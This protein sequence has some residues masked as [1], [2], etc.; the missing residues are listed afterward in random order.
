MEKTRV[1]TC[2]RKTSDE[3]R[4]GFRERDDLATVALGHKS[5]RWRQQRVRPKSAD[6]IGGIERQLRHI[7]LLHSQSLLV[8]RGN[9]E[10]LTRAAI[11]PPAT[12]G[13]DWVDAQG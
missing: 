3:P 2:L 7:A 12:T 6:G 4:R 8:R 10:V 13:A 11:L 1:R 9:E 5:D